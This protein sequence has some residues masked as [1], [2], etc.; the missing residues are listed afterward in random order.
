MTTVQ[1]GKHGLGLDLGQISVIPTGEENLFSAK[2]NCNV[3]NTI[4][5]LYQIINFIMNLIEFQIPPAVASAGP[6]QVTLRV[7]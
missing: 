3:Y 7:S 4:Y 1:L 2:G 5:R 6:D